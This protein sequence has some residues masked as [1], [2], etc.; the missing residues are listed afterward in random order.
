MKLHKW[1]QYKSEHP[2]KS[3]EGK[4]CESK[5]QTTHPAKEGFAA[6]MSPA[7]GGPFFVLGP[8]RRALTVRKV[9]VR[10][11]FIHNLVVEWP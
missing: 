2:Q 5:K 1:S 8:P 4:Y 3:D 9:T 6:H 11:H 10:F 7:P